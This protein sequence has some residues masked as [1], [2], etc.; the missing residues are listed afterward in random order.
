MTSHDNHDNILSDQK[1]H[2]LL[3]AEDKIDLLE[4]SK[5]RALDELEVPVPEDAEQFS[6]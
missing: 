6:L 4:K 1:L 3:R 2:D 5:R